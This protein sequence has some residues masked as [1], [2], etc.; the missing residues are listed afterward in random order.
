MML[1]Q[2]KT[3]LCAEVGRYL[4][5]RFEKESGCFPV[6]FMYLNHKEN[7]EQSLENLFASLLKQLLQGYSNS[8]KSEEAQNLYK[9]KESGTRPGWR[10]FYDAFCAETKMYQRRVNGI[11][12]THMHELI[13]S[14]H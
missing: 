8:L 11:P 5:R 13:A 10:E 9:G 1:T 12:S 4:E 7:D 14:H 2:T 6:L 3:I